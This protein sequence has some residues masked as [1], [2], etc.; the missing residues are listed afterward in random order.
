[1]TYLITMDKRDIVFFC[2]V[3]EV[4]ERY[5]VVRT[6]DKNIPLIEIMVSP[7]YENELKELL[8]LMKQSIS[9]K[10]LEVRYD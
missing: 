10:I 9:L 7:Y 5:G 6:I 8:E 1:M 4:S 2:S 3:L